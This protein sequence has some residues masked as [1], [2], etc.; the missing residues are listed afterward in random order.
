[1]NP[2]LP[3]LL[4]AFPARNVG[5]ADAMIAKRTRVLIDIDGHAMPKEQAREQK[6]AIKAKLGE[7]LIE[8][9]SGNGYGLVYPVDMPNDPHSKHVVRTLLNTLKAEFGCVD[10]SCFNA[11]R[12]TRLIGSLNVCDGV[13]IPTR[14]LNV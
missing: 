14:L 2:L 6:D 13:R 8:T 3:E 12:Q 1:L 9:D 10:A 4:T 7:P 5:L 11:G